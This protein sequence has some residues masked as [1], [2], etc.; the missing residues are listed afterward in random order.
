MPSGATRTRWRPDAP[1]GAPDD[2][3]F[4]LPPDRDAYYKGRAHAES[5]E[6]ETKG[7]S[8]AEKRQ[9]TKGLR[10]GLRGTRPKRGDLDNPVKG[11]EPKDEPKGKPKGAGPGQWGRGP[12]AKR[13]KLNPG[14]P[15]PGRPL[16]SR[17]PVGVGKGTSVAGVFLGCICYA[18][19][20]SVVDYGTKGPGMWFRAK[21]ENQATSP[22]SGSSSN[23]PGSSS[24]APTAPGGIPGAPGRSAPGS[25][26]EATTTPWTPV[27]EGVR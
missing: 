13:R 16:G 24:N 14:V 20:L 21:F 15:S 9:H 22:S 12:G 26:G 18:L 2:E 17:V 19:I 27:S 23:S 8:A 7:M 25:S 11:D 4:D 6:D 10:E 3:P 5:I 1:E